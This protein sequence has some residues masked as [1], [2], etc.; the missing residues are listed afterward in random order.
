MS[1]P[2]A[3]HDWAFYVAEINDTVSAVFLDLE[4]REAAPLA[5]HPHLVCCAIEKLSL[6]DEL[7]QVEDDLEAALGSL[8]VCAGSITTAERREIFHYCANPEAV[9]AAIRKTLGQKHPKRKYECDHSLDAQWSFYLDVLYPSPEEMQLI[10]NARTV[11]E[12]AEQGDLHD[13]TRPI[14]HWAYF[15]DANHRRNFI[16][17]ATAAGFQ[18]EDEFT[19]DSG[20]FGVELERHDSVDEIDEPTL[21]LYRLAEAHDG[22]YDGWECEVVLT[23]GLPS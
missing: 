8:S 14:S 18:V 22:D 1:V 10:Q 7:T 20:A 12:L 11:E 16:A 23:D 6:E 3:D 2:M 19:T 4:L 5:T 9:E 21:Q 17:E 13:V 15:S